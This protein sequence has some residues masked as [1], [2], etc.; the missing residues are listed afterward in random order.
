MKQRTVHG[1]TF[2]LKRYAADRDGK[3][4]EYTVTKDGRRVGGGVYTRK[5]GMEMFRELVNGERENRRMD[6]PMGFSIPGAGPAES[7]DDGMDM[8]FY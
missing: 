7:S 6:D 3:Q 8:P 5:K 4:Y 1:K 2:K